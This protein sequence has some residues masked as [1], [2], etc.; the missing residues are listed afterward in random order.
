[1]GSCSHRSQ[2][3]KRGIAMWDNTDNTDQSDDSAG[4]SDMLTDFGFFVA[5]TLA[6]IALGGVIWL[7]LS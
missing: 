1:M 3:Q 2:G 6:C 4:Y 5:L 7:V